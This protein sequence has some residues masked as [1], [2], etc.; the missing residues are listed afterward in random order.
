MVELNP[1]SKLANLSD[2]QVENL[3]VTIF[4]FPETF[5]LEHSH[6]KDLFHQPAEKTTTNA[7]NLQIIEEGPFENGI[8][9]CISTPTRIDWVLTFNP[10]N[11]GDEKNL[12][13]MIGPLESIMGSFVKLMLPWLTHS[14]KSNRLAFGA[15]L[16]LP[17]NSR[18]DGYQTLAPYLKS[19]KLD[20]KGSSDFLYQIN[21]T[22]LSSTIGI[23]GFSI[24]R[25]TRWSVSKS[26]PMQ[27]EISQEKISTIAGGD[28]HSCRLELDI[29]TMAQHNRELPQDRMASLFKE[30]VDLGMEIV[31]NGDIP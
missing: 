3:R 8:L 9:R 23:P 14:P 15:V 25:L 24:N 31:G 4:T 7:K 30:L 17:V 12:P 21:R 11:I 26:T 16:N 28:Q 1:K 10:D 18:E 22:R 5:S 20:P 19:V 29:N 13:P 2:W 6:F 27:L